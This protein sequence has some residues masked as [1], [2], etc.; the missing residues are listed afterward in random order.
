MREN[1]VKSTCQTEQSTSS[2]TPRAQT[3]TAVAH[4]QLVSFPTQGA[5]ILPMGMVALPI[6]HVQVF[7]QCRR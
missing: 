4:Q 6:A 5:T 1:L 7:P 2:A 3:I